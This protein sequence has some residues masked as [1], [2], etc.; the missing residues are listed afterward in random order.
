MEIYVCEVILCSV[1]SGKLCDLEQ[2]TLTNIRSVAPPEGCTCLCIQ[3]MM[4]QMD[5]G[6]AMVSRKKR[7]FLAGNHE[8][9]STS[10]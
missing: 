7:H 6:G 9:H 5:T 4:H 10:K 3:A 2:Q 1:D 8:V